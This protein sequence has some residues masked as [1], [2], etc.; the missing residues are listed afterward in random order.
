MA[1]SDAAAQLFIEH[2][3]AGRRNLARDVGPRSGDERSIELPMT[4][5]R[6]EFNAERGS[7]SVS[8]LFRLLREYSAAPLRDQVEV[9]VSV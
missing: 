6:F 7:H 4:K 1:P 2:L 5:E 9:D 3:E 8:L